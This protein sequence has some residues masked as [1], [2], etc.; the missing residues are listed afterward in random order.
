MKTRVGIIGATGRM[1]VLLTEL[2]VADDTYAL[3][4][5]FS[6]STQA[7][8]GRERGL[9][10]VFEEND[11][12]VDFSSHH[13]VE[14]ILQTARKTPKPLIIC[15]TGWSRVAVEKTIAS[16]SKQVPIVIASNTSVGACLQRHLAGVVA[17]LSESYD[18]DISEKHHRNKIDSPSGTAKE[19]LKT[20][21]QDKKTTYN[22][23]YKS[24]NPLTDGKR[25]PHRIGMTAQRSGNLAGE[26]EVT[27]TAGYESLSIK[28]LAFDRRLFAIGAL[29]I[30]SWLRDTP[31]RT[32]GI[33]NMF[34]VLGLTSI[35]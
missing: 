13:L 3:G 29:R 34:D 18:V 20:I 32:S 19:L 1:G 26:H 23:D 31:S 2:L 27:F 7:D 8:V 10:A 5:G 9:E 21:Q 24:Y 35:K 25:P 15:T 28:H 33:Y 16:I 22:V 6:R 4:L 12:V 14:S 30:I 11:M 17:E